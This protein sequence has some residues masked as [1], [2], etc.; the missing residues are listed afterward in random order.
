[1]PPA[2]PEHGRV[3][4]QRRLMLLE[5][6][7]AQSGLGYA[8]SERLRRADR[9]RPRHGSRRGRLL[10]QPCCVGRGRR[11]AT[12][13]AGS[14][15]PGRR[16]R[17]ARVTA[18]VRSA[19]RSANTSTVGI[20]L[21]WVV[22]PRERVAWSVYRPETRSRPSSSGMASSSRTSPS[23]PASVVPWPIS[24]SESGWRAVSAFHEHSVPPATAT[25]R[26]PWWPWVMLGLG[27]VWTILI[28][29]P[30]ILNAEDHLDS[31]LAVDGLTLLD[32][33]HG[34]W[35][36]HYPGTPYMGILPMLAPIPRPWSGGPTRSRW[37]AA[38]RSSGY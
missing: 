17:L 24:S 13:A 12:L 35:R 16:G 2:M 27:L 10:L 30:L 22:Y 37:S 15:R 3:C 23:Y 28:R 9:A 6:M 19:E 8:L 14:A 21:V 26:R 33:V 5:S 36:W 29:I 34:H 7:D 4:A 11:L 25:D 20:S 32:A 1:M 38:G 18:R 31:D